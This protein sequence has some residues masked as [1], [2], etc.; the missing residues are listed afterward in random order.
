VT[1]LHATEHRIAIKIN[2]PNLSMDISGTDP[3]KDNL[4]LKRSYPRN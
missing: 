2:G 4:K 1:A 3:I